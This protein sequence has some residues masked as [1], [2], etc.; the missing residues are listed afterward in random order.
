LQNSPEN[1]FLHCLF[2]KTKHFL[3]SFVRIIILLLASC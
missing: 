2:K 3:K 1:L